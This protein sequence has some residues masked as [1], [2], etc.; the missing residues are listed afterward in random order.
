MVSLCRIFPTIL[1]A[2]Q[3]VSILCTHYYYKVRLSLAKTITSYLHLYLCYHCSKKIDYVRIVMG[4]QN[5]HWTEDINFIV[6]LTLNTFEILTTGSSGRPAKYKGWNS[7][8]MLLHLTTPSGGITEKFPFGTKLSPS[9]TG[10]S[11]GNFKVRFSW[12]SYCNINPSIS[13]FS[14]LP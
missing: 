6:D 5:Y 7:I 9:I 3:A 11:S 4:S 12:F 14:S 1:G 10:L 13:Q 2:P 8:E